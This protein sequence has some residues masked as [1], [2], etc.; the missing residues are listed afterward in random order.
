MSGKI[1][2]CITPAPSILAVGT[3]VIIVNPNHPK[4]DAIGIFAG[5]ADTLNRP[6]LR[7]LVE[8]QSFFCSQDEV[9][10]N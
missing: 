6:R 10:E 9:I 1:G 4:Y 7:V 8:G 3:E 5:Y 2:E